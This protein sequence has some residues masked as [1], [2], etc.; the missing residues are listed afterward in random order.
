MNPS[1]WLLSRR[2]AFQQEETA[3]TLIELLVVIAIIAILA[4]ML[5]PALASARESARQAFCQNNLKQIG[6]GV[7]MYVEQIGEEHLPRAAWWPHDPED[8]E[9][10]YYL[11]HDLGYVSADKSFVCP[12]AVMGVPERGPWKLTYLA[13][14]TGGP[15]SK[16]EQPGFFHGKMWTE[17][18]VA[19]ERPL[20]GWP[21]AVVMKICHEAIMVQDVSP[22]PLPG[23]PGG[24]HKG[25]YNLLYA[26]THVKW[27]DK[28]RDRRMHAA[29]GG[30]GH[31]GGGHP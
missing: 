28:H 10:L 2:R 5:M 17:E 4:G 30:G 12:S 14:G 13:L 8:G 19:R 6:A 15:P 9:S 3:F 1:P 25:G 26:D 31:H 29:P 11:L 7:M 24:P 27:L 18:D 23:Y 22:P 20:L 16:P 21:I